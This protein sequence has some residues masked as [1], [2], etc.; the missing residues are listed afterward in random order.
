MAR[1][2]RLARRLAALPARARAALGLA[3]VLAVFLVAWAAVAAFGDGGGDTD[4]AAGDP[5][6]DADTAMPTT[7]LATGGVDVDAPDGWQPIPL[8]ELGVGLAVPPGWEAV[9]LSPEGL[10]TLAN[11]SPAVPD[12]VDSAHAAARAGGLLYAA[13]EDAAGGISDVVLR[14]APGTGVTDAAGLASYAEDLAAEAG[15][16][17]PEV[18]PVDGAAQPTVRLRF[19]VGGDGESAEG[20]ETFVLGPEGIVWS[21]VVTTDDPEIHDDLVADIAG[22]LTFADA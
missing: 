11:A 4:D 14:A 5:A 19:Q 18:E 8:P 13:G 21:L 2:T 16:T 7:T 10:A 17:D 9:L 15:R 22:T 6:G 3:V 12:F 1:V 20:T